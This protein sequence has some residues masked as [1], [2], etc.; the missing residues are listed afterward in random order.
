MSLLLP[1]T[2]KALRS[3]SLANFR[4]EVTSLSKP[5]DWERVLYRRG[6]C[7]RHFHSLSGPELQYKPDNGNR[8]R[9]FITCRQEHPGDIQGGGSLFEYV[10]APLDDDD[11]RFLRDIKRA[12]DA[13]VKDAVASGIYSK[14]NRRRHRRPGI[15]AYDPRTIYR[16]T[17]PLV[18][19][20]T[21]PMTRSRSP[22]IPRLPS[23][24][25]SP[26]V[27]IVESRPRSPSVELVEPLT[28]CIHAYTQGHSSPSICE[29]E[30]HDADYVVMLSDYDTFWEALGVKLNDLIQIL[31][32]RDI[33][34]E[35][36]T[37]FWTS[38]D[39]MGGIGV[40]ARCG[41]VVIADDRGGLPLP[42]GVAP[43]C[44]YA[45]DFEDLQ[46]YSSA[47]SP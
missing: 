43:L 11:L 45:V 34:R 30:Y 14:R 29:I 39:S 3:D 37:P 5:V 6:R 41:N 47:S 31:V 36:G 28:F 4:R 44:H 22:S 21:T 27:Q 10:S 38:P 16:P 13:A 12:S 35:G 17:I 26:S 20:R 32:Y 40:P 19:R 18:L 46:F 9:Y 8:G 1:P 23:V 33:D 42:S 15:D 7:E 25:R 24:S 2:V